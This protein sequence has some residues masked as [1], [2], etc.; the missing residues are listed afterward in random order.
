M[1]AA[2]L[3]ISALSG[4]WPEPMTTAELAEQRGGFRLPNGID[5]AIAVQTDTLVDQTLVLRSVYTI[6]RGPPTVRAWT[7]NDPAAPTTTSTVSSGT[8]QNVSPVVSYD[9]RNGIQVTP[10]FGS[11]SVIIRTGSPHIEVDAAALREIPLDGSVVAAPAGTITQAVRNGI[12]SV[13]LES[14][15]LAITHLAGSAI[16]SIIEN[17]GSGRVIDTV[18]SVA[19]ELGNAGPDKLG[20]AMPRVE[21]IGIDALQTRIR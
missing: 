1:R 2:L 19:I 18:T 15:D 9:S 16:G 14:T 6:D 13:R 12:Q 8:Q 10:G 3:F 7:A 21:S 17:S 11:P 20:S 5:V 4:N